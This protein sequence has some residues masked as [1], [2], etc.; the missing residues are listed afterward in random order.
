MFIVIP[1]LYISKIS[2]FLDL[3]EGVPILDQLVYYI[4][5]YLASPNQLLAAFVITAVTLYMFADVLISVSRREIQLP[6]TK[7]LKAKKK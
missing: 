1:P 4:N 7:K 2:D 5:D 3:I 6:R